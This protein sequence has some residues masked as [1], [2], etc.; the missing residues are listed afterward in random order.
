MAGFP[1]VTTATIINSPTA[2]ITTSTGTGVIW[3]EW[4]KSTYTISTTTAW[5]TWNE[6]YIDASTLTTATATNIAWTVWNGQLDQARALIASTKT[7]NS[8]SAAYR[9]KTEAGVQAELK[10]RQEWEKQAAERKAAELAAKQKAEKLLLE[11]LS[12]EQRDTLVKRGFF[13]LHL[14]NGKKY[15]LDRH[16]HGNVYLVDEE[17]RLVRKF[18]AQPSGVP[19]DDA[20]L[21]QKLALE[22]DEQ[23]FLRVANA[24]NMR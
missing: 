17:N 15:R 18:C 6:H 8:N 10:Q 11:N 3:Q 19:A 21:A 5:G 24:T 13:Y 12:A 23:S 7:T 16:T 2:G 4:N 9:K 20:I 1:F 14:Q 22:T